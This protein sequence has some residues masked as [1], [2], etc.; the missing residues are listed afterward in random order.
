L[1]PLAEY[2]LI[3]KRYD[4]SMLLVDDAHGVAAIGEQ[5][6]G[7]IE[8]AGISSRNINIGL[9]GSA[10]EPSIFLSATLS[11]AVGGHGGIIPGSRQFLDRVRQSSGW[12]AGA[13]APA[14]PVAAATAKGL[15]IVQ[16]NPSLRDQLARNVHYLRTALRSIGLP[17]ELSPSPI[18][19]FSIG[20]AEFMQGLQQLLFDRQIAIAYSRTYAG[21]GPNGLLRIAV[22]AT[23]TTEMIDR[24]I[25]VLQEALPKP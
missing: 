7:S 8:V 16:S 17:I 2:L 4:H 5:G 19:G 12:F 10:S 6:R 3:L 14:A 1:A 15:E 22:F 9:S 20:D 23:H 21:T 25:G 18:I 24:L 11:K 13:S